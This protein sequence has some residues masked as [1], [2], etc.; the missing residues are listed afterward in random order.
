MTLSIII[1]VYNE[2]KTIKLLLDKVKSVEF[3]IKREIIVVDDCSTDQT[4][5]ISKNEGVKV[6][7]H[8]KNL[9]KGAAFKT[10]LNNCSGDVII[11]QDA[12]LEYDP[13][14]IK[15]CLEPILK[16]QAQVVYG[17]RELNKKNKIHSNWL[18]FLGGKTVTWLTN[19]LYNSHLTDEPTCYKCFDAKLIKSIN[20]KGNGFEWEPEITAKILKRGTKIKEVP[21]N[22]FPRKKGK[23]MKYR[24]GIKALWT[25]LKYRF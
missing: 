7:H 3:G 15:L 14:D 16:K 24:D 23:K 21:I 4:F 10:G 1:P 11:I 13:E 8:E 22:Y 2:Q 18:F 19:L 6:F 25:L 20:I 17:S 5:E 12:D 9:G